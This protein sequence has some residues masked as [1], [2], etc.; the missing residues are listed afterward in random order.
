MRMPRSRLRPFAGAWH[1]C[2]APPAE[3]PSEVHKTLEGQLRDIQILVKTGHLRASY[4]SC[5]R[6]A[7][8]S[9]GVSRSS[10]TSSARRTESA[11]SASFDEIASIVGRSPAAAR[12]LASR[13]RRRV[14]GADSPPLEPI[15]TGS[16][17][18]STL[19]LALC[20]PV[21]SRVS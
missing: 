16:D 3:K 11:S 18:L 20:V 13:A 10:I 6:N 1:L 9:A 7:T 19:F 4:M 8:R 12:Q 14:Q 5:R 21:T 2:P 15:Y 17:K